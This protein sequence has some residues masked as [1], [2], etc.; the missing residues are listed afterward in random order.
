MP[1]SQAGL[2]L[3]DLICTE[4]PKHYSTF[5]LPEAHLTSQLEINN[6]FLPQPFRGLLCFISGM[7]VGKCYPGSCLKGYRTEASGQPGLTLHARLVEPAG[8]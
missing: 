7:V 5:F 2:R 4:A 8:T 6:S 1:A 3:V